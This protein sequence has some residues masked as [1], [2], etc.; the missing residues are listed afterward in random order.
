MKRSVEVLSVLTDIADHA[1][2]YLLTTAA[3]DGECI[4][5]SDETNDAREKIDCIYANAKEYAYACSVV[6]GTPPTNDNVYLT[7]CDKLLLEKL[8]IPD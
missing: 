6:D 8:K 7:S 4:F 3:Q 2:L 5:C 1:Y